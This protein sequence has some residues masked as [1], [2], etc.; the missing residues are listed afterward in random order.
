MHHKPQKITEMY[1]WVCEE[2]DGGEGVPAVNL[3]NGIPMPLVGADR[4]RVESLR[5]YALDGVLPMGYPV[6][7]V[8]FSNMEV[9]ERHEPKTKI[10]RA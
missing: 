1:A 3:G 6:K 2:P 9:L 7:L 10:T 4:E 8:R 5:K